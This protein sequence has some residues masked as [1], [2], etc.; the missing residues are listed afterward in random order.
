MNKFLLIIFAYIIIF[1]SGSVGAYDLRITEVFVD[2]SDEFVEITNVGESD[3]SGT[4]VLSGVKSSPLIVSNISLASGS[5]LLLGDNVSMLSSGNITLK[6]TSLG[7]S[8]GDTNSLAVQ[9]LFDGLVVDE[10]L[11]SHSDVQSVDNTSTSFHKLRDGSGWSV[12]PT[13][14]DYIR[15]TSITANPGV[16]Y[17]SDGA[18][19]LPLGVDVVQ[20][21]ETEEPAQCPVSPFV[22]D[23]IFNGEEYGH[24]IELLFTQDW[25]G[26]IVLS[27]NTLTTVVDIPTQSRQKNMRY[28]IAPST[29]GLLHPDNIIINPDLTISTGQLLISSIDGNILSSIYVMNNGNSWYE[30][31]AMDCDIFMTIAG[32]PS[33]GFDDQFLPY[34]GVVSAPSGPYC[35]VNPHAPS[36]TGASGGTGENVGSGFFGSGIV[37]LHLSLIDYDPPGSDT[38]TERIGLTLSG[39]ESISLSGWKIM[40]ESKTY[41]FVSGT[42]LSGQEYIRIANFQLVN[43]RPVCVNLYYLDTHVDVACYDPALH[44]S[45]YLPLTA[46][47]LPLDYANIQFNIVSLV[48]DPPGSDTDAESITIQFDGGADEILLDNL[49]LRI[50]TKTKRIYGT[51]RSGQTL[52]LVGNFQMPNTVPTCVALVYEDIVYDE[53]CYD[54]TLVQPPTT[55]TIDYSSYIIGIDSLVYDPPGSDTDNE[56]VIL[57]IPSSVNLDLSTL[58]LSFDNKKRYLEGTT[59]RGGIISVR[60]NYQFP[61][62]KATCVELKQ[63][64]T[65]FDTYCYD[66]EEDKHGTGQIF[67]GITLSGIDIT[68]DNM[69]YDPP[70]SDTNNE[71]VTLTV[72]APITLQ[73]ALYLS[74][75]N[76]KKKL[77]DVLSLSGSISFVGN[78]QL[79]NSKS[80]CVELLYGS[81][82][83]DDYCY[84]PNYKDV[85][86]S[87]QGDI[88]FGSGLQIAR[89]LPNPK[90]KDDAKVNELIALS[91]NG[92]NANGESG[93]NGQ[94][95]DNNVK[96]K[97]NTTTI[98]LSGLI[99]LS[100]ET[101]FPAGKSL[102]N[103]PSCLY[104]YVYDKEVDRLCYPQAKDN[105]RY[106]HPRLGIG[107]QTIPDSLID[108]LNFAGGN[109]SKLLLKKIDKKICLT[110]EG[111]QIRCINSGESATSKKN[112]ALL[113][114]NNSYIAQITDMYYNNTLH[115]TILRRRLNS[116][117]LLSKKIKNNELSELNVY[118]ATIKPTELDRYVELVYDQSP[119]EY[120]LDQFGRSLF[121]HDKMDEYYKKIYQ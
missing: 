109:L 49:R 94:L 35:P 4:I 100:G 78:Y 5:L 7:L 105:T 39:T 110:Y 70:G 19:L 3:F 87:G 54:P 14:S 43:S 55:S 8:L 119:D 106:Y 80:I 95:I 38:N 11:V 40:Y 60:G 12:F 22:V 76:K 79:P 23:E 27:G 81:Q 44:P 117:T 62:N 89:V 1:L 63:G 16:V 13:T 98:P 37:D 86:L 97:I 42:V 10:F 66:P 41:N 17:Q 103:S 115:P 58:Y 29:S 15:G 6:R 111:V 64:D 112:R 82:I 18:I 52:K 93:Q 73:Q 51:I 61:N 57:S 32:A 113:T 59:Y 31:G 33:P 30:Q 88:S 90:G 21:E 104:L 101:V 71:V 36:G 48:Y 107:A 67:S 46:P 77:S 2:G 74:F 85:S 83:L 99:L 24:Y 50:G 9:L 75:D 45:P 53:Y 56:I 47:A 28:L 120:L 84:D 69:V 118:G 25:E 121:G 102:S 116:Y 96:L 20:P 92:F 91:W 108:T 114:L 68:I 65:V 26:G 72:S 34:M